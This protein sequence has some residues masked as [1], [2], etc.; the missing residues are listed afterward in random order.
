VTNMMRF[1]RRNTICVVV[2]QVLWNVLIGAL[3]LLS[4]PAK[5]YRGVPCTSMPVSVFS[6]LE[7][8]ADNAWMAGGSTW[9]GGN[10]VLQKLVI[11]FAPPKRAVCIANRLGSSP[12]PAYE[13][14]RKIGDL[15][16]RYNR[17]S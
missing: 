6:V 12:R 17:H 14:A 3:H 2:D 11:A 16:E 15:D 5:K 4:A 1:K 8:R 13:V 10:C 9:G 7:Q